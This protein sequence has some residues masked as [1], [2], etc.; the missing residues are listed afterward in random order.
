MVRGA[1]NSVLGNVVGALAFGLVVNVLGA[2]DVMLQLFVSGTAPGICEDHFAF[3]PDCP[4]RA[5]AAGAFVVKEAV[6][7]ESREAIPQ[8]LVDEWVQLEEQR[9]RGVNYGS[10]RWVAGRPVRFSIG[11]VGG[12]GP[13]VLTP[14]AVTWQTRCTLM[15]NR[16]NVKFGTLAKAGK[17]RAPLGSLPQRAKHPSSGGSMAAYSSTSG[18]PR[19]LELMWREE[20]MV[21]FK[22]GPS[23]VV[24]TEAKSRIG[25]YGYGL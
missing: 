2:E 15:D 17:C 23:F 16:R 18:F 25:Y 21:S 19:E 9:A 5:P 4:P 1:V 20:S 22:A 8:A 3:A 10:A 11:G 24:L 12:N 13:L 7:G 6:P 14:E